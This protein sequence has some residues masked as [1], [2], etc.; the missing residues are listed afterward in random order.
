LFQHNFLLTKCLSE[1]K[2][3]VSNH[4]IDIITIIMSLLL[5]SWCLLTHELCSDVIIAI[6]S[7]NYSQF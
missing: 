2:P 1:A 6:L 4:H 5:V 3:T 7:F